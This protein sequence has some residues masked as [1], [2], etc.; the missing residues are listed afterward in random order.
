MNDIFQTIKTRKLKYIPFKC[1]VP[2]IQ[3]QKSYTATHYQIE[4]F[5][6]EYSSISHQS[7]FHTL[8]SPVVFPSFCV[9]FWSTYL[10]KF[11]I[12]LRLS[13]FVSFVLNFIIVFKLLEEQMTYNTL[14]IASIEKKNNCVIERL[15]IL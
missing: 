15:K 8:L 11:V 7:S 3:L 9:S 2:E 13:P 1:T 5:P 4:Y 14:S 10:V 12:I 6:S